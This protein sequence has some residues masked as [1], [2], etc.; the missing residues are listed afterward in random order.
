MP[1]EEEHFSAHQSLAIIESMIQKAQNRFSENGTLYLLWGWVIFICCTF[2]YTLL[3]ITQNQIW[4]NIWALTIVAVL[5]QFYFLFKKNKKKAVRTYTDDIISGV[6]SC[7]GIVMGIASFIM[8]KLGSWSLLYSFILLFYGI[9]TF[10]SGI[11][12]RFKPL[13][14]GGICCWILSIISVFVQTKEILLL[15]APAVLSAWIIP[16]Y[17]LKA[18]YN[19][20]N[21]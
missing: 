21:G 10:L 1:Q 19:Q 5:Y 6:W 11:I 3:T 20:Q 14:I 17:L 12:M 9:P 8:Y 4:G 18:K 13:I 2:H 7:F 15:L 16:G